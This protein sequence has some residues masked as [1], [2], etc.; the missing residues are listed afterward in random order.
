MP[1]VSLSGSA[2]PGGSAR[3]ASDSQSAIRNQ[4]SAI[5]N[6]QS[7]IS[8]SQSRAI[9]SVTYPDHSRRFRPG[10]TLSF[11]LL[12]MG[13]AVDMLR[14]IVLAV[15]L[16]SKRGLGANRA[17]FELKEVRALGAQ[18]S[19]L[20]DVGAE[21][22][23]LGA[24]ASRL[25]NV[26]AA[27]SGLPP[28]DAQGSGPRGLS[29]SLGQ[30]IRER[31]SQ[32]TRDKEPTGDLHDAVSLAGAIAEALTQS[33]E[34][35]RSSSAAPVNPV[36]PVDSGSLKVRFLT[37]ARIRVHG[38]LQTE[39]SFELL[40]RNLLRRVSMLAAV[41]GEG[42]MDLDY[43]G[44]IDRAKSVVTLKSN[45]RWWDLERYTDRQGGKLKVGGFIGEVEYEGEAISEFLPLLVAGEMLNVGTGTSFGL[46]KF[47]LE[48]DD[49]S[50]L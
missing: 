37:P 23:H 22:P 27:A 40:V 48:C 9:T 38:D 21:A 35:Q 49:L 12:L 32:L 39:L 28:V 8:N 18:A 47:S 4:Q 19:R 50:P 30:L 11:D 43:R 15:E 6:L 42:P 13:R 46:G 45:L 17:S 5:S 16:M 24:Q 1:A 41:H 7:S 34:F 44:L 36:N 3:N 25:Q 2:E 14:Y 20:Q 33:L 10:D 29:L 26:G 31:L